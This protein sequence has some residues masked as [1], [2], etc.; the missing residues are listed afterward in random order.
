MSYHAAGNYYR[1]GPAITNAGNK[2][3]GLSRMKNEGLINK[4]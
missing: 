3:Y 1:Y 2:K 4:N